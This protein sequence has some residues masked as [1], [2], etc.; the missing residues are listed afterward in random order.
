MY[1]N[2]F[3]EENNVVQ[4]QMIAANHKEQTNSR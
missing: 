3:A 4:H 2:F 1:M